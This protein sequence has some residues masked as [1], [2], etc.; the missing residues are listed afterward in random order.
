MS[1]CIRNAPCP[2]SIQLFQKRHDRYSDGSQPWLYST[3]T[4]EAYKILAPGPCPK[5][6]KGNPYRQSWSKVNAP[7]QF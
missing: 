6:I 1:R 7:G 3:I 2:T 5:T 4:W